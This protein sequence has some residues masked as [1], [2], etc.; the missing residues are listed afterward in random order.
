MHRRLTPERIDDLQR[1][2]EEAYNLDEWS[3]KKVTYGFAY[4]VARNTGVIKQVAYYWLSEPDKWSPYVDEVALERA[5]DLDW[6]V[7]DRLSHLEWTIF[8]ERVARHPDPFGEEEYRSTSRKGKDYRTEGGNNLR[9]E[10]W[11]RGPEKQRVA[12]Q[13]AVTRERER[14]GIVG[15]TWS[16]N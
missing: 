8:L 6:P 10:A 1:V 12:L 2:Y 13:R 11:S 14:L 7:I 5:W 4:Q 3:G 15:Q 9:W 16:V